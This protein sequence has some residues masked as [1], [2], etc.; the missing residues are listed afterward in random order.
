[1]LLGELEASGVPAGLTGLELRRGRRYGERRTRRHRGARG[2]RA[3]NSYFRAYHFLLLL[4]LP[5]P[6]SICARARLSG[7]PMV[8]Y[9]TT[10]TPASTIL[11]LQRLAS[12]TAA[13]ISTPPR[14]SRSALRFLHRHSP[15]PAKPPLVRPARRT[16]G[17]GP[18]G[19]VHGAARRRCGCFGQPSPG[20]SARWR[21]GRL[22]EVRA[23][24]S[25]T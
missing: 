5:F 8:E 13:T 22:R 1:V 14:A 16:A 11:R 4:Y 7:N 25:V 17:A 15:S 9:R 20:G 3:T 21:R 24:G 10:C 23:R 2:P 6:R 18:R 19:R 12:R